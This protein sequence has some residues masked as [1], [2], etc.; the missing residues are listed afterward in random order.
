M[1]LPV[2]GSNSDNDMLV[3]DIF[4]N[5]PVKSGDDLALREKYAWELL[6]TTG[7]EDMIRGREGGRQV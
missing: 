7:E 5:V 3:S 4:L 1:E 6:N 2:K